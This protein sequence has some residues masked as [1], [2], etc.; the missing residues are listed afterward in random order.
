MS[1]GDKT[2]QFMLPAVGMSSRTPLRETDLDAT[3]DETR[4]TVVEPP[5]A[6]AVNAAIP[7]KP[8]PPTVVQAAGTVALTAYRATGSAARYVIQKTP[9][10]VYFLFVL[11]ASLLVL[12]ALELRHEEK[13]HPP[14][15]A[16]I[17]PGPPEAAPTA[18]PDVVPRIVP[19]QPEGWSFPPQK[20]LRHPHRRHHR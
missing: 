7:V 8:Q 15:P 10:W 1:H 19:K 12:M 11:V 13:L 16:P 5:P 2:R 4:S 3:V 18:P 20:R 14:A 17:A 6:A 9:R